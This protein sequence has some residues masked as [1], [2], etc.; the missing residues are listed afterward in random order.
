M[1]FMPWKEV[2]PM[3][4]KE[5]YVTLAQ[6]GRFTISELCKV[7][8]DTQSAPLRVTSKCTTFR[9]ENEL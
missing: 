5:R 9:A 2:E 6:S 4:E 1:A 7:S 3:Q 8:A